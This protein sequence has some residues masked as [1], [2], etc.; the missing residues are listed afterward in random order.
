[1]TS[2]TRAIGSDVTE[3]VSLSQSLFECEV[4]QF[5]R[6]DPT[7][8]ARNLTLAIVNQFYNPNSEY[9]VILRDQGKIIAYTW[10]VRGQYT[11][12]SDDETLEIRIAHLD[13]GLSARKRVEIIKQM[14]EQ[15]DLFA[16]HNQIPV[17]CSSTV[18]DDQQ[19]F[20]KLHE[21]YGYTVKGSIA[22]KRLFK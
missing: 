9:V 19:A 14:I 15:W 16:Y 22:W 11:P 21:R 20:L 10:A 4:D 6:T 2:W 8:L 7:V 1:M 12:W 18:R 17:I 3:L 13:L 5:Y